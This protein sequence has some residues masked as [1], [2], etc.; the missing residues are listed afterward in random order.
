MNGYP[1]ICDKISCAINLYITLKTTLSLTY[2]FEDDEKQVVDNKGPLA[3]VTIGR[4]T[5]NDRAHRSQHEDERDTEGNIGNAFVEL[6]GK[7][8]CGQRDGEEVES[9]PSLETKLAVNIPAACRRL[10]H[11][12]TQ[13]QNAIAKKPQC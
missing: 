12:L 13:A 10:H 2:Q 6:L 4:E 11:L 5:E 3:T 1:C 7:V 8:G 9:I